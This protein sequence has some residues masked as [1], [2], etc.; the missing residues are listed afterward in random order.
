LP[1]A[2]FI[3]N[4]PEDQKLLTHKILRKVILISLMQKQVNPLFNLARIHNSILQD[5]F[6]SSDQKYCEFHIQTALESK[7][8]L[9]R[10]FSIMHLSNHMVDPAYAIPTVLMLMR[11]QDKVIRA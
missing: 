9:K 6:G 3:Q 2:S 1:K 11:D 5:Q 8:T 10:V 7:N 4:A